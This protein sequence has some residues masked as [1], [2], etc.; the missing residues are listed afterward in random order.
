MEKRFETKMNGER[1]AS[2]ADVLGANGLVD[3][4]FRKYFDQLVEMRESLL[5]RR[6]RLGDLS[7]MAEVNH[8]VNVAD[9]GSDEY[10]AGEQFGQFSS[11]QDAVYEIDQALRRIADGSY[12]ICEATGRMIPEERLEA[13]PWTRFCKEV[14]AELEREEAVR[15]PRHIF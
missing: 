6:G 13:I 9:R 15:K 3:A 1:R 5:E 7:S 11:D 12:G 8:N 4:R 14:E 2:T 10:D